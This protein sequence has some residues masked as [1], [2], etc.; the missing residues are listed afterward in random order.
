MS[1]RL[2]EKLQFFFA[3]LG[4]RTASTLSVTIRYNYSSTIMTLSEKKIAELS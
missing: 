2:V 3:A 4:F 1:K